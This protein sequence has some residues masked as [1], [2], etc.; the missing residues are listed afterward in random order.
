MC[1][2]VTTELLGEYT[3][4]RGILPGTLG[5][6]SRRTWHLSQMPKDN[7]PC[8]KEY[9]KTLLSDRITTNNNSVLLWN[10]SQACEVVS[11]PIHRRNHVQRDSGYLSSYWCPRVELGS[12][13][14]QAGQDLNLG[15]F[16]ACLVSVLPHSA[17]VRWQDLG[18]LQAMQTPPQVL[19]CQWPRLGQ[20]RPESY[21]FGNF[22]MGKRV[23]PGEECLK[24]YTAP[25]TSLSEPLAPLWGCHQDTCE[26]PET[27]STVSILITR[28]LYVY[29]DSFRSL[30]IVL[31]CRYDR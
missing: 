29:E 13:D 15:L 7:V 3:W 20:P 9:P 24:H 18:V 27:G 11:F 26:Q 5:K 1:V 31:S 25:C 17:P 30:A 22:S 28:M 12:W 10:A 21:V 2:R 16:G 23:K 8:F 14:K 4:W 19:Q 6:L